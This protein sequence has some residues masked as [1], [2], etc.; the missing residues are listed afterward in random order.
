MCLLDNNIDDGSQDGSDREAAEERKLLPGDTSSIAEG[1]DIIEDKR[2]HGEHQHE[3]ALE[4]IEKICFIVIWPLTKVMPVNAAPE[5][6]LALVF[7][8]I[9]LLSEFI[10]TV[11]NVFSVYTGLSH[12]LV[13]LTLMVWGSDQLELIN[14]AIAVKNKQCELGMTSVMSCQIICL[15][16]II[17]IAAMARMHQRGENEIQVMQTQHSRDMVILPP[18]ICS[19]LSFVIFVSKRM[20]LDRLS[21]LTLIAIYAV[22]IYY[23]FSAF[24]GDAD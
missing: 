20:D 3:P 15:I 13:G 8:L 23:G 11:F 1:N 21:S 17:P 19:V 22:Y 24:G 6:A 18:L 10:L 16:V 14:M 4:L 12:F 2:E 9:Y 7:V 5:L